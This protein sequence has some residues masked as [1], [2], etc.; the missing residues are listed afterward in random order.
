[1]SFPA[2]AVGILRGVDPGELPDGVVKLQ[3]ECGEIDKLN[4][5]IDRMHVR[6]QAT[7]GTRE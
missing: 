6:R 5:T 3:A 7:K 1:M 4:K 2:A